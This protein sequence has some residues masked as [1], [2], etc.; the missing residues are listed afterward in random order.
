MYVWSFWLKIS[1]NMPHAYSHGCAHLYEAAFLKKLSWISCNDN[2]SQIPCNVPRKRKFFPSVLF[3]KY[4]LRHAHMSQEYFTGRTAVFFSPGANI[5]QVC[6]F[7]F[8]QKVKS[9][10]QQKK[11]CFWICLNTEL[12]IYSVDGRI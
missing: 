9:K 10:Q 2:R 8:R 12:I 7:F 3:H 5:V 4:A 1:M 11:E 6:N